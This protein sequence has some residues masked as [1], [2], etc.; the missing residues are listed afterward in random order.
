MEHQQTA[1][2]VDHINHLGEQDRTVIYC[3]YALELPEAE[4]AA[5]LG[6]ARGTVKSRLHRA[7]GRLRERLEDTP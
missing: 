5:V 6:C 3:R 2:L 1:W 4:I 7:L